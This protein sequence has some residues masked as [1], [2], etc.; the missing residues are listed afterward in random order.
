MF[1]ALEAFREVPLPHQK[2]RVATKKDYRSW[3]IDTAP[4]GRTEGLVS[5]ER[6]SIAG[7]NFYFAANNPLYNARIPGSI[8]AVLVRPGVLERLM[9]VQ[10]KL[11]S[12]GLELLV[13]D[14][15]RPA[16]VQAY[17]HDTWVPNY[18]RAQHPEWNEEQ[19]AETV[20]Q[21]WAWGP[22]TEADIDPLSPPP[23]STGGALDLTIRWRNAEQLWMGTL[24]DDVTERAYTGA[25]EFED[26]TFS[27]SD[28]EARKNRRLLYAL[29]HQEGFQ[30]NPTEWWHFSYG[31]QMWAKLSSAE[32]GV[33]IKALYS[34]IVPE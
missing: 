3:P 33:E 14:A 21:Y 25:F 23:H 32:Q 22:A 27:S 8:D 7:K 1:G 20:N 19:L 34:N 24:V 9:R 12:A 17:M 26:S 31:D 16:A 15:W 11:T 29:M 18:L 10:K 6:A 4:L 2:G 13:F 28:I 5:I 30:N